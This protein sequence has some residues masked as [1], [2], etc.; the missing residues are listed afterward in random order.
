MRP[1]RAWLLRISVAVVSALLWSGTAGAQQSDLRRAETLSRQ[2]IQLHRDGRYGEA[3][4]FAKEALAIQER[5]LG[6]EHPDV[7]MSLNTLAVLYKNEGHYAEAEPLYK[8]S[9]AIWEKA[10]GPEHPDVATSLSNLAAVY[11]RQNRYSEAELIFP[12]FGGHRC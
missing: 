1:S 2:A 7:A 10:L 4:P 9:L 11:Q 5:V 12:R 3:I 8:R 6:I